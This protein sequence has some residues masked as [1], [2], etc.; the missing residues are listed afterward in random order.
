MI[1]NVRQAEPLRDEPKSTLTFL[2]SMMQE[3]KVRDNKEKKDI[4][5]ALI[6]IEPRGLLFFL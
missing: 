6:H 2:K 1:I 3:F 5:P 4:G